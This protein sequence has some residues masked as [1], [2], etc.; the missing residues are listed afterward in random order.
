MGLDVIDIDELTDL[1][2]FARRGTLEFLDLLDDQVYIA[3]R[4][5]GKHE[6]RAISPNG[7]L[8]FLAHPVRHDDDHWI[9]LSSSNAGS[10]NTAIAGGAFNDSHARPQVSTPLSL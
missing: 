7:L 4:A 2:V 8:A 3:L 10:G 5:R 6:F 9:A 1:P